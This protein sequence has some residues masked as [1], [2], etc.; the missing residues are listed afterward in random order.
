MKLTEHAVQ[1]LRQIHPA[2]KEAL[3]TDLLTTLDQLVDVQEESLLRQLQGRA[4]VL[5]ELL[6]QIEGTPPSVNRSGKR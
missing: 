2:V 3:T 1:A 4:R 5:R 6:H